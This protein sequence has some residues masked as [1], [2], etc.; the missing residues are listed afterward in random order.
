MSEGQF[1][2]TVKK[3]KKARMDGDSAKSTYIAEI[4]QLF[5][6]L[7]VVSI[8]ARGAWLDLRLL[9][10][11]GLRDSD[12]L[13]L[14]RL[15]MDLV[16]TLLLIPLL[17]SG[18][19]GMALDHLLNILTP[20]GGM[21]WIIPRFRAER[22]ALSSGSKRLLAGLRK[23]PLLGSTAC[24]LILI[25]LTVFQ[26]VGRSPLWAFQY[27]FLLSFA[28]Y[29]L[30][31]CLDLVLSRQAFIKRNRMSRQELLN[32]FRDEEGDPRLKAQ[33]RVM[34]ESMTYKELGRRIRRS[35]VLV[36]SRQ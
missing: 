3:L 17:V 23:M 2:P 25:T 28:V 18:M 31:S 11:W 4:I 32:E 15:S 21:F 34:R 24:A 35:K 29:L 14:C 30:V 8:N 22:F 33:L 9:L 10:Q 19:V 12:W 16:I 27:L 1:P 36:V 7:G 26:L 5:L 13:T 6:M 20:P